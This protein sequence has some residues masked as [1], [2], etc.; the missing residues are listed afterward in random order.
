MKRKLIILAVVTIVLLTIALL[1][2]LNRPKQYATDLTMESEAMS[3]V[4]YYIPNRIEL[5]DQPA[6]KLLKVPEFISEAPRYGKLKLG[7]GMDSIITVILDESKQTS[8]LYI[9]KN[10]NEDLTDDDEPAWDEDKPLYRMKTVLIEVSYK[11]KN[12]NKTVPYPVVFYRYKNRFENA[13]IAY[14]D[15]FRKGTIALEDTTYKVALLDD[16]LNGLFDELGKGTIIIDRNSDDVLDGSD[17]SDEC[18]PLN[19]HFMIGQTAYKV[20]FI[21]PS[22]D[23]LVLAE[24]DTMVVHPT[25][26]NEEMSA[27]D[28]KTTDFSGTTIQLSDFRNKVVL[29]DFWATWCKPWEH[30]LVDLQ[31]T[32]HRYHVRGFEIIGMNLDYDL[33]LMQAF[34][35]KNKIH[36]PQITTGE[37]WDMPFVDL[38][39]VR[40]LPKRFLID[41]KGIIRYKDLPAR[42]LSSKVYELLNEPGDA[43][44]SPE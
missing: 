3:M 28:F 27:P 40:F 22:G 4:N 21:S 6:E 37:G 18:F 44:D 43:D 17:D 19:A 23:H 9:D 14:R 20:K 25:P 1:F 5:G 16:D 15:G 11:E 36:W 38:F 41:R 10:N 29:I 30:E 33:D 39:H 12:A 2:Y 32:Y 24:T 31:R 42:F 26:L 13:V 35:E 34:I 7:N 8:L